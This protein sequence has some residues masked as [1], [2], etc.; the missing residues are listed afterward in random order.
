[1]A[2]FVGPVMIRDRPGK[3][4]GLSVTSNVPEGTLLLASKVFAV[5]SPDK[6]SSV[7]VVF[8][9]SRRL[10]LTKSESCFIPEAIRTIRL[11]P[12]RTSQLYQLYAGDHPPIVLP[13]GIIDPGRINEIVTL[14]SFQAGNEGELGV[15]DP[16]ECKYGRLWI[17]PS[18]VNH[19]YV[20]NVIRIFMVI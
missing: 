15:G 16:A 14:N 9:F 7:P 12:Q 1:M 19:R 5:S 3:G 10:I 2:D 6:E 13:D 4:Q 8:D 11:N 18:L 20:E 17:L